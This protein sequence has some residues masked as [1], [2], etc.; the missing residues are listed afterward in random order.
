[1]ITLNEFTEEYIPI[2]VEWFKNENNRKYMNTK[3]VNLAEAKKIIKS[4]DN[5][6]CYL[7]KK[8]IYQQDI[9]C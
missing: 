9:V 7:I 8:K 2:F 5:K 4:N 6:K 3:T 1:M